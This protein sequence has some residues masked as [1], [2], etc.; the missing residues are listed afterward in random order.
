MVDDT[1]RFVSH[2]EIQPACTPNW[3]IQ[4]IQVPRQ[5]AAAA[6]FHQAF[7]MPFRVVFRQPAA[8]ARGKDNCMHF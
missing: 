7:R 5:Q 1:V 6:K 2:H 3:L 4:N 8:T